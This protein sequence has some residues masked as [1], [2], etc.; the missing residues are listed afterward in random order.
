MYSQL[1]PSQGR[2]D[3][4]GPDKESAYPAPL[5]PWEPQLDEFLFTSDSATPFSFCGRKRK[6]EGKT[7]DGK[8]LK[9]AYNFQVCGRESDRCM[10]ITV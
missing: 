7:C 6:L 1:F 10:M 9:I 8:D 5:H 4:L 3:L 2:S